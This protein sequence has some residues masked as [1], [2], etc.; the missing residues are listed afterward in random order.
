M[1]QNSAACGDMRTLKV[2]LANGGSRGLYQRGAHC[3]GWRPLGGEDRAAFYRSTASKR[4]KGKFTACE[5]AANYE[6]TECE[7]ELQA[8]IPSKSD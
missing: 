7:Q 4:F 3:E 8:Q 2:L 5:W 6:Q 1:V